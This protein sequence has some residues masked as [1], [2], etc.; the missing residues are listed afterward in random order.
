MSINIQTENGLLQVAGNVDGI[1]SVKADSELSLES[2][3]PVQNKV[4]TENLNKKVDKTVGTI[5]GD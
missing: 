1:G 4:I 5:T 2:E 3:K